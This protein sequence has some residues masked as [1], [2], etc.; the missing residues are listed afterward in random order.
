MEYFEELP[1]VHSRT[2][3]NFVQQIRQENDLPKKNLY[4]H[5]GNTLKK[6]GVDMAKKPGWILMSIIW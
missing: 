6:W 5:H 1:K 4:K 2:V 3:Y